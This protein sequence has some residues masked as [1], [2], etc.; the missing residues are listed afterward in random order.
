MGCLA[1]GLK[2]EEVTYPGVNWLS[3]CQVQLDNQ[4]FI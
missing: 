2:P 4:S 3:A 1:L